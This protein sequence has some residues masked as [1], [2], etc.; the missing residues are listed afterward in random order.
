VAIVKR[1]AGE[2]PRLDAGGWLELPGRD[3]P[4]ADD[5][6]SP[7]RELDFPLLAPDARQRQVRVVAEGH[8]HGYIPARA[9]R[10]Q[11]LKRLSAQG[12]LEL[13]PVR[14]WERGDQ[15]LVTRKLKARHQRGVAGA[16]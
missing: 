3:P 13:E 14:E 1:A 6:V 10:S 12:D 11:D 7:H 8:R 2:R 9:Q 4:R 5:Y 15:P 16:S